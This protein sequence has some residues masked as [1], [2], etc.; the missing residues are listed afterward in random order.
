M[1]EDFTKDVLSQIKDQRLAPRPRWQYSLKN[2]LLWCLV[3][4]ATVLGALAV[5]TIIY[6][7]T[8][9]DWDVFKYL[10]HSLWY[11]I[12]V[13]LPYLWLASLTLLLVTIFYNLRHTK[14][15]YH[16][17]AYK[18]ISLSVLISVL[19]GTI[20]FCSGFDSEIHEGLLERFPLYGRLVQTNR[21]VWV[22]PEQGLLAGH[23]IIFNDDQGFT[24]EDL[25]G[26]TW[27]VATNS[28]TI[29][30]CCGG[31]PAATN[32]VIKLIGTKQGDK[33]FKA[34]NIRSWN[35][36]QVKTKAKN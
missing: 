9:Y 18:I 27:L 21:D 29:W 28:Q 11:Q 25:H 12:F 3:C 10:N 17:E 20:M 23:I 36:Q 35:K 15:G 26:N 31:R 4:L 33:N 8:D 7:L 34:K 19:L 22:Y 24:L 5:T 16:Y 32:T 1:T 6:I 30:D 14:G 13:T 2:Y